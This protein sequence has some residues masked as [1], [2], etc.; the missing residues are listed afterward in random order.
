MAYVKSVMRNN[1]AKTENL[2]VYGTLRKPEI[3]K[4]AFGRTASPR[5][6]VLRGY[7]R[8]RRFLHGE[9]YPIIVS[10]PESSVM[11]LVISVTPR[12]LRLLDRY[13]DPLYRRESVRIRSGLNL[14][15]WAYMYRNE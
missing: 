1:N 4:E 6:A 8:S 15:A 3:Q 2:F 5:P 9:E 7:R 14:K 10:D 13:E 12:E 11:G